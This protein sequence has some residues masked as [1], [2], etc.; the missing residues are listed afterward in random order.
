MSL[1]SQAVLAPSTEGTV[2][3]LP[4]TELPDVNEE[5][6]AGL[7][8]ASSADDRETSTSRTQSLDVDHL[9]S[10]AELPTHSKSIGF[11]GGHMELEP[12]IRWVKR[13]K[14][15][16]SGTYSYGTES[17]RMEEA[18]SHEKVSKSSSKIVKDSMTSSEPTIGKC[19]GLGK[20]PMAL[21]QTAGLLRNDES[22]ST[23]NVRKTQHVTPLNTWI[24]RW[25]HQRDVST[26]KNN[27]A[28]VCQPQSSNAALEELGKKQF[29][30]IAAMALM[31]KA[32]NSFQPCEF[33]KRGTY[34]VWNT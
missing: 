2:G 1:I 12:S 19:P 14:L 8:V 34:I 16:A 24:Q 27:E 32:L 23:E 11:P 3:R 29:P 10:H 13:L 30:S 15:S 22:S 33:R 17:S 5:L 25:C 28:R 9:F 21:D 6:P 7:A 4:N 20:E 26:K 18:S 31:G